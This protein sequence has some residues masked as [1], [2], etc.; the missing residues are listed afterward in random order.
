MSGERN[1]WFNLMQTKPRLTASIQGHSTVDW[2]LEEVMIS[3]DGA[4]VA[5][6]Y[7][8]I[9]YAAW[10]KSYGLLR[11]EFTETEFAPAPE[12]S[13]LSEPFESVDP[14]NPLEPVC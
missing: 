14:S 4:I 2:F 1:S 5:F 7:L 13:E 6:H 9:H 12:V 10:R 8:F 3:E 11:S